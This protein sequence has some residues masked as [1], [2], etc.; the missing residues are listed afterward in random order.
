LHAQE[1]MFGT[2]E[3]GKPSRPR[4]GHA[5]DLVIL[6]AAKDLTQRQEAVSFLGVSPETNG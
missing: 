3:N 6:S 2:T 4:K 5:L 1:I